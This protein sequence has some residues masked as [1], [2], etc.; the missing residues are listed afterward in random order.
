M[1]SLG[2][3]LI[4]LSMA[5]F[6]LLESRFTQETSYI[7][8]MMF[9]MIVAVAVLIFVY[10]GL[11][12]S[13][14]QQ[15]YKQIP[16]NIYT[17]EELDAFHKR[18]QIAIAIGMGLLFAGMILYLPIENRINDGIASGFFML[19]VTMAVSLFVY[20]GTQKDKYDKT[21]SISLEIKKE[22]KKIGKLCGCVMLCT[23]AAY[24]LWS[25]LWDSWQISWI[26]FPIGGILCGIIAIL[27]AK[28]E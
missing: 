22:D 17:E 28:D 16:Q 25:F 4:L 23:L 15:K 5:M 18:F 12:H 7:L 20:Y 21:E 1:L 14:F 24:L 26:L 6:C 13:R 8:D 27:F 9:M 19:L 2:V 11:K 3:S 10:F